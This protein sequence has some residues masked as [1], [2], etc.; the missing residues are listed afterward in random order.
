MLSTYLFMWKPSFDMK[1]F[2][3]WFVRKC[4]MML[5]GGWEVRRGQKS[6]G[7]S[8]RYESII[9]YQKFTVLKFVSC[10]IKGGKN[11]LEAVS[12]STSNAAT[13]SLLKVKE[14]QI[15]YR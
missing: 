14:V 5:A 11:T 8:V 9:I 15:V 3:N 4:Q 10:Y 12:L 1:D 13:V 2:M 7:L 6:G